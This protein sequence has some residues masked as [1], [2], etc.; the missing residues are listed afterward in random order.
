MRD[1]TTSVC[2]SGPI[3]AL[4]RIPSGLLTSKLT[5]KPL[6]SRASTSNGVDAGGA[7]D[8]SPIPQNRSRAV[9]PGS[10]HSC[11]RVA[12]VGGGPSTAV[13]I[14]ATRPPHPTITR[15]RDTEATAETVRDTMS[16]STAIDVPAK[17][18][19]FD[20]SRVRGF[21]GSKVRGFEGSKVRRFEGSRVR[22]VGG[23]KVRVAEG[24]RGRGEWVS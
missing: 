7:S 3:L 5:L 8:G 15:A 4:Q 16:T 9:S 22:G 23:W 10:T 19:G 6:S 13:R 17:V 11:A 12:D 21:E 14:L 18:R 24:A 1:T 2:A 20:G